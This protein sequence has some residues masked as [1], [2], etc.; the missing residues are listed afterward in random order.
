M[1]LRSFEIFSDAVDGISG[2][3]GVG[4]GV[5]VNLIP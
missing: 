3:V 4:V 2:W 1:H 5:G